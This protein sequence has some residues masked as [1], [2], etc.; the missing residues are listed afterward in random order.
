VPGLSGLACHRSLLRKAEHEGALGAVVAF[1]GREFVVWAYLA[2]E[3]LEEGLAGRA[4]ARSRNS[5]LSCTSSMGHCG[6]LVPFPVRRDCGSSCLC[7]S[8]PDTVGR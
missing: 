7:D 8:S 2:F 4:L 6:I 5:S 1:V 3:A